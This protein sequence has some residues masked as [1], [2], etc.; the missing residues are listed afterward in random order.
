MVTGRYKYSTDPHTAFFRFSRVGGRT[1]L[2][3]YLSPEN[4]D[5]STETSLVSKV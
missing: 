1:R 5:L 3:E 4:E 2:M